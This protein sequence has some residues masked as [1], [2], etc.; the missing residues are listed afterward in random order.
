MYLFTFIFLGAFALYDIS[1]RGMSRNKLY[2]YFLIIVVVWLIAHDGLRW[3]VG[4]DWYPY[5][6]YFSDCISNDSIVFEPGYILINKFIRFFTDNYTVFLLLNAAVVYILIA[7]SV[8]K[9][10]PLPLV[11]LFIFYCLMLPYMGANRQY[12]ALAISF[13]SYQYIIERKIYLFLM[14]IAIA[15]LFHTSA[16][17]FIFA[18]FLVN[19]ISDKA[20]IYS[21][22]IIITLSITNIIDKIAPAFFYL[23]GDRI[24]DKLQFY[25]SYASQNQDQT[26]INTLLSLSRRLLLIFFVLFLFN[27]KERENSVFNFIFN[28]YFIAALIYITFNKTSLQ[29]IVGRG[30]MYYNIAEIFLIPFVLL[31]FK[32]GYSRTILLLLFACY[33]W[34]Q[35]EK[36]LNYYQEQEGVDIFR[37]YNSSLTDETHEP[38][39]RQ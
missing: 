1:R 6:S 4:T 34:L 38:E 19:R 32:K 21:L 25:S 20:I 16:L 11:S 3:G 23:I 13:F 24:G 33:G 5:Y 31:K 17:L 29:I 26:I 18:Y 36:G 14:V 9:Y 22:L 10:S 12:I 30:M 15:S 37:P 8:I 2:G 7:K 28:L 35:I 27:K 39:G